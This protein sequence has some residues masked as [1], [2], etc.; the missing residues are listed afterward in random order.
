MMENEMKAIAPKKAGAAMK[1]SLSAFLGV[2]SS[3]SELDTVGQSEQ[4]KWP[5]AVGPTL[6]PADDPSL[7]PNDDERVDHEEGK[8]QERLESRQPQRVSLKS[9]IGLSLL[10]PPGHQIG[11]GHE[12]VT[13]HLQR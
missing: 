6:H 13:A 9:A 4:T 12:R 7:E 10:P 8:E 1:M 11:E 5:G 3:L 2:K